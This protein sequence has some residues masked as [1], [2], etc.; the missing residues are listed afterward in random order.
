MYC[1]MNLND[2]EGKL[3][4]LFSQEDIRL[5]LWVDENKEFIEDINNMNIDGEILL[6]DNV[7]IIKTKYLLESNSDNYLIYSN[8]SLSS[9]ENNFLADIFSYAYSFSADKISII[10]EELH[11]PIEFR[12]TVEKYSKFFNAKSRVEK[13][14]NLNI[15][16]TSNNS[17]LV[18]ILAV[19]TKEVN[20]KFENILRKILCEGFDD[21]KYLDLLDKYELLDD[22]WSLVSQEYAFKDNKPSLFKLFAS[23]LVTYTYN[24]F[25]SEFPKTLEQYILS[26]K[27]N[28]VYV[29]LDNFMKNVDYGEYYDELSQEMSVK[30][31]LDNIFRNYLVDDFISCDAFRLF[32]DRIFK[33][34]VEL[35]YSNKQELQLNLSETR[36]NTHYYRYYIN[37]Y[38]LIDYANQFIGCIN[39]FM[40]ENLPEDINELINLFISKYSVVDKFYRK[41]YYHYDKLTPEV[42]EFDKLEDLRVLIED[43]Y[44][45]TFLNDLN[46]HF[47]KLL[48]DANSYNTITLTKQWK[49][50][51]EIVRPS[52]SKHRTVVIISDAFRFG[53]AIELNKL[54]EN[55][56]TRKTKLDAMLSTVPSYTALGM[57]SLLPNNTI[58]YNGS[59]VLVD[60]QS[61]MG[62][63]KREEILQAHN[64][65]AKVIKYDDIINMKRKELDEFFK[66]TNLIYIYH[67][68]VDARG[69]NEST[70]NEVFDAVEDSLKEID[71]LIRKIT[72]ANKSYHFYITA[73]HGF[74]YKRDKLHEYS[75]V[76]LEEYNQ[77]E[78]IYKNRRFILTNKETELSDTLCIPMDYMGINDVYVTVPIGVNV[79]KVKG[80]GMN[81]V[82]GGASLQEVIIPLLKVNT[83]TGKNKMQEQVKID[84]KDAK[85]KITTNSTRIE[86]IQR[87]N[88]SEKY[89]PLVASIYF[90]DEDNNKISNENVIYADVSS[91]NPQ[92]REFI[93]KFTFQDKKYPKNKDYYL[94]LKDLEN[95]IELERYNY[96][97]DIAFQDDFE[98]F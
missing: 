46:I 12:G 51:K 41:F 58:T 71:N 92:D 93:K 33:H 72:N 62:I 68:Q 90:V 50:Y 38:S 14:K 96:I 66:D 9:L 61:T 24:G 77:E 64:P 59:N 5:V 69:D 16:V 95:D 88:I 35:L 49:F 23:M 98:F 10:L 20:V 28:N 74:I 17:I 32:D 40:E 25:N 30:L 54:M 70:E 19:C 27:E 76:N 48:K 1:Y 13:F 89:T 8:N 39:R 26:S 37:H 7:S 4:E 45:N 78:L 67:N 53:N 85:R 22:F 11:I 18:G 82:H 21:N 63:T 86:F 79:F 15:N 56:P 3:N 44:S 65:N 34:Y 81:F 80:G 75:K 73:D 43:M 83:T 47:N 60:D 91:E 57:A 84:L 2:I 94:V 87:N 52:V 42:N 29:F 6:L 31:N 97:I 55:D 36:L